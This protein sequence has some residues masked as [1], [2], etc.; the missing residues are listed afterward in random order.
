[1]ENLYFPLDNYR[2]KAHNPLVGI[3]YFHKK[4]TLAFRDT[5]PFRLLVLP[6][7]WYSR[8]KGTSSFRHEQTGHC[9]A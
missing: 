7:A 8:Q 9:T 2:S 1:M 3:N 6:I 4:I 5:Y